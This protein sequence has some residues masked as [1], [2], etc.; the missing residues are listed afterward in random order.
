MIWLTIIGIM[1]TYLSLHLRITDDIGQFMPA[2]NHNSQLQ[3]L[4]SEVQ[5]GPAATTLMLRLSGANDIELA[6]I[7][8]LLRQSLILQS[9]VFK[10][11]R[12][13]NT[14]FEL[15]ALNSLFPYRYLLIDGLNWS[16]P[17]LKETLE[18]RLVD[19]RTGA[20]AITSDFI[21]NDPQLSFM[22][23]LHELFKS[24]GPI[25]KHGV[26]FDKDIQSALL[27]ISVN[28][29]SLDLDVMQ[30]A[31]D[32]IRQTFSSLSQISSV[33]LEISGPG[34]MAVQVRSTIEQVINNLS[35]FMIILLI[36]VFAFAY[37]SMYAL[38]LAGIPLL[39]AVTVS[40]VATQ[41]IFHEVHGIVLAFG[42]TL[43]SVCLDYPLHLFSHLQSN[44]SPSL[45]LTRIWPTLLLS[46]TSTII[47]FMALF[48]SGFNGL[49][50]LSVFAA[51]GLT[52]ALIVTRYILPYW[53]S[54]ARVRPGL[55]AL[56]IRLSPAGKIIITILLACLPVV[57]MLQSDIFWETSI[58]AI[59]PV[60]ASARE[61][62]RKLRHDLNAPEVSHVFLQSDENIE[63]VLQSSEYISQQLQELQDLGIISRIWS[64]SLIL[65]SVQRQRQR[66]QLLPTNQELSSNLE[67]A[68]SGLPYRQAAF[69]PWLESVAASRTLSPLKYDDIVSTPLTNLLKP[70]LFQ[71]G[72]MWISAIRVS[73]I[74][75]KTEFNDWLD[76]HPKVK[77]SHIEIKR[78][79]EHLLTEYR[80][81]TFERFLG[82]FLLLSII[83][84]FWIGS[85]TRALWILLP[86]TIGLLS[87][88]AMPILMGVAINVFHLL[89]LLLVLGM[90]LDY[91][92]FFNRAADNLFERQQH[93]HAISISA[94]TTSTAFSVLAF[95][96]VSVMAAMGQTVASGILMCFISALLLSSSTTTTAADYPEYI[97]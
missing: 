75:S 34:V 41:A 42:I 10:N 16:P 69:K 6:R 87:G 85:I 11:V 91:S 20:G 46:G 32:N 83:I 2:A 96:P 70:G 64:P 81:S 18:Q 84:A 63:K 77:E 12:N 73:D 44:E 17:A 36:V 89:A 26:W 40:L 67:A 56:N 92:L 3:A 59:S 61:V 4:M 14:S 13:S 31:E 97:K 60:P 57:I 23:Y 79:T 71:H 53:V 49:S 25:V 28:S 9:D 45:S 24:E 86:V 27:L 38:L 52:T 33:Q 43:L 72:N 62:D 47:A 22:R 29:D 68:L 78:A 37:R 65:P 35:V 82:I 90:G 80:I 51:C 88:L 93:L 74:R 1:I 30:R 55:F 58:D 7:S 5:N 76:L 50:Q 48:G 39:S 21:T 54:P 66:Q 15:N 95:S 19:L 8:T 94:L